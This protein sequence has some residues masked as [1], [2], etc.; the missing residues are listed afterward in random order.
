MDSGICYL[1]SK[2]DSVLGEHSYHFASVCSH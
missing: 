2:F 1:L